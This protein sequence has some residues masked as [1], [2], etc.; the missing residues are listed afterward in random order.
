MYK[1]T[2]RVSPR[3]AVRGLARCASPTEAD[4]V[5]KSPAAL[6][7]RRFIEHRGAIYFRSGAPFPR[8]MHILR[9]MQIH[10]GRRMAHQTRPFIGINTDF[11]AAGKTAPAQAR[12]DAGYFDAVVAAGGMPLLLP[13][14]A[15]DVDL[16]ALLDRVDGFVLTGGLD[17]DPRRCSQPTNASVQPMAE[18]REASDRALLRRLMQRRMPLLAIGLGM[19]QLNVASGGSLFLNL[20]E[21]LPRAI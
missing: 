1:C 11:V 13:P 21:D 14:I 6:Y 10:G 18:R 19:Q 2:T 5:S 9:T 17:M 16:D 4:L 20:P 8:S 3:T 7:S 15:K 12:V